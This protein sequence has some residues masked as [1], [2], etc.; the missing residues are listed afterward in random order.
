VQLTQVRPAALREA[1]VDAWLVF[2]PT[3]LADEYLG[4]S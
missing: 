4:R 2:A 1:V 3:A